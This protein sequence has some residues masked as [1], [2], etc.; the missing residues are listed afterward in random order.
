MNSV[1]FV[2]DEQCSCSYL[3]YLLYLYYYSFKRRWFISFF[4]WSCL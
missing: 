2:D 4:G 1:V 3:K